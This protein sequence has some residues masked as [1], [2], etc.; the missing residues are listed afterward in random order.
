[1]KNL[2]KMV[3]RNG[4]KKIERRER[5]PLKIW[6][7]TPRGLY[8]ALTIVIPRRYITGGN[9]LQASGS[10]KSHWDTLECRWV[11]KQLYE[12]L[13]AIKSSFYRV[14]HNYSTKMREFII[15]AIWLRPFCFLFGLSIKY[16]TLFLT[17]FYPVTV[18]N[19]WPPTI[20]T[21]NVSDTF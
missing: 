16:V 17:K 19:I 13:F 10:L 8:P 12:C 15:G 3:W 9:T 18:T 2:R 14:L 11:I 4:M 1:M 6:H 5:A 7:G 20:T 21:I